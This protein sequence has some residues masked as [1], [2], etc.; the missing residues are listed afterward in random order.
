MSEAYPL[1]ARVRLL[2]LSVALG[3][4][5]SA[6]VGP[7]RGAR[8]IWESATSD[9]LEALAPTV[10]SLRQIIES[11][12]AE[13]K[14][15]SGDLAAILGRDRRNVASWKSG[16]QQPRPEIVR[17]IDHLQALIGR[18]KMVRPGFPALVLSPFYGHPYR[19][20]IV[21]F[22]RSGDL[23]N[24]ERLAVTPAGDIDLQGREVMTMSASDYAASVAAQQ[25][26]PHAMLSASE[27]PETDEDRARM[28]RL[29]RSRR[30][31]RPNGGQS[32][33]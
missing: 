19:G 31:P 21:E 4:G 28:R 23:V 17:M 8:L 6:W 11:V 22:I 18:L 9:H 1:P 10:P 33:R 7:D 3:G 30:V 2:D 27:S 29:L 5:T 20:R 24:A 16:A 26:A 32:A 14:L 25:L 12:C 15:T 13:A